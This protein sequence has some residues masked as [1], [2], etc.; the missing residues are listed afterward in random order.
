MP[1]EPHIRPATLEDLGTIVRHRRMMFADIG[2]GDPVL[3]EAAEPAYT[4][5]LR[6]RMANGRYQGWF[7]AAADGAV[8]AGVGLWLMD[9]PPGGLGLAPYR[10]FVFNVF[11]ERA[12]RKQGFSRRLMGTLLEACTAQGLNVV[13]LHASPEARALYTALGFEDSHEM[14]LVLKA[15]PR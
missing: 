9:W 1:T 8:L 10:G 7:M 2:H 11:T 4:A 14:R 12:Y 6:E 15:G 3:L 13:G 5:W